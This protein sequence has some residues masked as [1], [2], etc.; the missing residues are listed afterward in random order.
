MCRLTYRT[1]HLTFAAGCRCCTRIQ[2]TTKKAGRYGSCQ[3]RLWVWKLQDQWK[4]RNIIVL[5]SSAACCL[6]LEKVRKI[7]VFHRMQSNKRNSGEWFE[8]LFALIIIQIRNYQAYAHVVKGSLNHWPRF[9]RCWGKKSSLWK[10]A[11]R[12]HSHSRTFMTHIP[13]TCGNL[14]WIFHFWCQF[15]GQWPYSQVFQLVYFGVFIDIFI[16]HKT[17]EN[18]ADFK[19]KLLVRVSVLSDRDSFFCC[20]WRWAQKSKVKTQTM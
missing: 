5:E 20:C 18:S 8:L 12:K 7:D 10:F 14:L 4:D 15:R 16:M 3:K 17:W 1:M 19:K 2:P 13:S 6:A 11:S 9:W